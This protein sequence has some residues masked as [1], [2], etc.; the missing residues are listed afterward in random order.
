VSSRAARATQRH[1]VLKTNKELKT[2]RGLHQLLQYTHSMPKNMKI[3][4]WAPLQSSFQINPGNVFTNISELPVQIV[5][6]LEAQKGYLMD[7]GL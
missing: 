2:Q 4:L 6:N 5:E 1:P 3:F 7:T